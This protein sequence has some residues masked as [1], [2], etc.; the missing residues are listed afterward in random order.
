[1]RRRV[2]YLLAML[3]ILVPV[4]TATAQ[5]QMRTIAVVYQAPKQDITD[6]SLVENLNEALTMQVGLG[7]VVP[8][9]GSSRPEAPNRRFDLE[10]LLEW[11]REV[12]CRYIIY[13]RVDGRRIA[14]RKQLSI[15]WV[16]SRYVVEGHISGMYSL[17][18]LNR[19]KVIGTWKLTTRMAG[20]RQW[21]VAADYPGDPD[22]HMSAP[23]K[24][25]FLRELE[26]KA[27]N[28]IVLDVQPHLRG[29]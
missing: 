15:P 10:R 9:T 2:K 7:V 21:Q 1:M 4:A 23:R 29:R 17:I 27:V 13:L 26:K 25:V 20:P 12:G 5:S 18:D 22:L 11:G 3:V 6:F 16:L 28:E 19:S 8:D 24:L 14:T